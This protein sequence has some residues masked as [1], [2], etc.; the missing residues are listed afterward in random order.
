MDFNEYQQLAMRTAKPNLSKDSLT[1]HALHGLSGEVGELHSL[2]QKT[3]QGHAFDPDHAKKELGDILWFAAEY[4][5]VHGWSLE[6]VAKLNIDKLKARYP[7]G[8]SAE[9]SLHRNPGDI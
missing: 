9:R 1:H 7:E 2:H 5:F 4:A 3:Y 8:F 6:E